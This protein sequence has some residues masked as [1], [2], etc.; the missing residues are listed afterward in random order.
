L[1]RTE[2][3]QA[4]IVYRLPQPRAS[5]AGVG[6]NL[7]AIAL[8]A[9]AV[10]LF[11]G[12]VLFGRATMTAT[13]A[14]T[15]TSGAPTAT[16]A[17]PGPAAPAVPA[18]GAQVP[19]PAATGGAVAKVG[20][21]RVVDGVPVG[22]ARSQQGAVAAATNYASALSGPIVLD[23][24]RR[25]AAIAVIAAPEARAAIQRAYDEAVPLLRKGLKA[26]QPGG[27]TQVLL[28]SIPVGWRV[29]RYDGSRAQISIWATGLGG[30]T[31]GIPVQEGWGITTVQ[32]RWV[33]GDWKET[34]ARTVPGPVPVA[35]DSA[36]TGSADLI[37][38]ANGFKEYHYAPGA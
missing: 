10:L 20:P 9:T 15:A 4:R 23:P 18:T 29:D 13:P 2:Q 8:T 37:G 14:M 30:S 33:S 32:L 31:S 3:A 16:A 36:P 26:D 34:S 12:G 6:G 7:A 21:A 27:G 1:A 38:Q 5:G 28:R 22:W 35:D 25:R 11:L 19:V 24:A 17:T